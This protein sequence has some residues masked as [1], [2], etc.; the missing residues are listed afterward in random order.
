[1]RKKTL[2]LIVM[3]LAFIAGLVTQTVAA[4]LRETVSAILQQSTLLINGDQHSAQTLN[5][6]DATY[7]PLRKIAELLGA[8]VYWDSKTQTIKM[9]S[10]P[11]TPPVIEPNP[12]HQEILDDPSTPPSQ[13][14]FQMYI[15][16]E[17]ELMAG[18]LTQTDWIKQRGPMVLATSITVLS[19]NLCILIG[20]IRRC[21]LRKR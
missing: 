8:D 7:V 3:C 20:I 15:S 18:V 13:Q 19:R 5:Y 16:P 6:Q 1:M 12:P 21:N 14:A 2:L 9:S 11:I 17:M 10:T 4:P